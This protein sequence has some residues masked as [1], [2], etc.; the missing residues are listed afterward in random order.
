MDK[1]IINEELSKM[2]YLLGYK[3][4]VVISEQ[5]TPVEEASEVMGMSGNVLSSAKEMAQQLGVDEKPEEVID[6]ENPTCVPT[7]GDSE[8]DGIIS[9][10]WDWANDPKNRGSLKQ[11]I[12]SLK[13]AI[14]KAKEMEEKGEINEQVGTAALITIGG[15]ALT[16]SLLIAIGVI[17]LFI[18]I[19]V[20]IVGSSK[21]KTSCGRR[22]KLVRKF[23]MDGNFM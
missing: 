11:T 7:T 15:V 14:F 2:K 9:R 21:N 17:L 3:R 22:K 16:P 8:K 13:D 23:G 18:L 1:K 19:I 5:E 10:I 20:S 6:T 4:G 12:T